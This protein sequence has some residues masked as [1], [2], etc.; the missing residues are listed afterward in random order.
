MKTQKATVHLRKRQAGAFVCAHDKQNFTDVLHSLVGLVI[1]S[2]CHLYVEA[3][4]CG[5]PCMANEFKASSR[6]WNWIIWRRKW[7]ANGKPHLKFK[8]WNMF[9]R[10]LECLPKRL[11]KS[12]F[13]LELTGSVTFY[14]SSYIYIFAISNF[15]YIKSIFIL[16]FKSTNFKVTL[17]IN[18]N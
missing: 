10:H 9:S 5:V 4:K 8:V 2:L 13:R 14:S 11:S 12:L 18:L 17:I 1:L 7:S 15:T 16:G 6:W 3:G